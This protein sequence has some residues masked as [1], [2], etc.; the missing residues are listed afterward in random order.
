MRKLIVLLFCIVF[1]SSCSWF[2][3]K[4]SSNSISLESELDDLDEDDEALDLER[5][6]KNLSNNSTEEEDLGDLGEL[7]EDDDEDDDEDN[8]TN[9]KATIANKYESDDDENFDKLSDELDLDESQSDEN[10]IAETDLKD[11]DDK[12]S[13]SD[14]ENS[15]DKLAETEDNTENNQNS[16]SDGFI[17]ANEIETKKVTIKKQKNTDNVADS[18]SFEQAATKTYVSVKKIKNIP[19]TVDNILVN[20]VYI[21]RKGDTLKSVSNKIYS[22]YRK[23]QL[24]KINP[25][26]KKYN[27]FPVATKIYYNSNSR[28]E[29]SSNLLTYYEEKNLEPKVYTTV[30]GDNL[31][32]LGKQLLGGSRSWQELWATNLEVESKTILPAGINIRYWDKSSLNADAQAQ[33]I[34]NKKDND[35]DQEKLQ[36]DAQAQEADKLAADQQKLEAEKLQLKAEAVDV[37]NADTKTSAAEE[38]T[39]T[40]TA[41]NTAANTDTNTA[42][43]TA[44]NEEKTI[45][46]NDEKS[47]ANANANANANKNTDASS[48][49]KTKDVVNVEGE[50]ADPQNTKIKN[51][52]DIAANISDNADTKAKSETSEDKTLTPVVVANQDFISSAMALLDNDLI[53]YSLMGFFLLIIIFLF[54]RKRKSNSQ[55]EYDNEGVEKLDENTAMFLGGSANNH[56][57]N[58]GDS[59]QMDATQMDSTQMDSTQM[60][61]TQMDATQ[62]DATQMGSEVLEGSSGDEV[63]LSDENDDDEQAAG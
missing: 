24:L 36:A 16:Y 44:A 22:L 37:K 40:N 53:L 39:D 3:S 28:P 62:M 25:H 34:Q 48:A 4:S 27:K 41:A 46:V 23:T 47:L 20:A 14:D 30:E 45:T 11:S 57:T 10:N 26:L 8:N 54:M 31:R 58:Q 50:V 1:M 55:N 61:S 38:N 43:N 56:S 35:L 42:K 33:I 2:S 60:D 17:D 52:D 21:S 32:A 18:N 59:T 6:I 5:D 63:L 13:L 12:L 19:Y 51:T 29:D 15:K 9:K 7:D 49:D